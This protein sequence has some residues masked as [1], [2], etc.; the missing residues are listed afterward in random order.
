[1]RRD[2]EEFVKNCHECQHLKPRHEF[3]APLGDV[4]EPVAPFD[5]TAMDI[6]G[7][8]PVTASKINT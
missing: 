5:V 4:S 3:K 6:V 8:L 2:V 7:S 1:M